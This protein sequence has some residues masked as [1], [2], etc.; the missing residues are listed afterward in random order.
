MEMY[1]SKISNKKWRVLGLLSDIGWI[2]FYIGL[3]FYIIET[4]IP[5]SFTG[6]LSIIL[7]VCG[8]VIL[9][10]I[11]EIIDERY[12]K[13]D[14]VLPKKRLLRGFGYTVYGSLAGAVTALVALAACLVSKDATRSGILYMGLICLGAFI[15][16]IF[17]FP[18]FKAFKRIS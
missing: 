9:C 5:L 6:V 17:G 11:V 3:I 10:G 14:R 13:L 1:E 16:F 8:I 7:L 12:H 15:C 2:A 18:I 4:G